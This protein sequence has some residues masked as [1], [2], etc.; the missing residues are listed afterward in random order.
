MERSVIPD[1]PVE[2]GLFEVVRKS[3]LE[4][5]DFVAAPARLSLDREGNIFIDPRSRLRSEPRLRLSPDRIPVCGRMARSRIRRGVFYNELVSCRSCTARLDHTRWKRPLA[6]DQIR[7]AQRLSDESGLK[8]AY[9]V[10][11]A[12]EIDFPPDSFDAAAAGQSWMYFDDRIL[13]PKLRR[14]G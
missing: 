6:K 7:E 8:I 4:E 12:E 13:V 2:T 14:G 11:K 10:S 1:R 3:R 5:K 9:R